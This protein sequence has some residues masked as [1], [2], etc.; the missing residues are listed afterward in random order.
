VF[1]HE[2][3]IKNSLHIDVEN[4]YKY[5]VSIIDSLHVGLFVLQNI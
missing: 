3:S 4:T 1:L 2:I 5:S